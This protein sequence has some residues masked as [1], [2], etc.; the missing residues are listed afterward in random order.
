MVWCIFIFPS[1]FTFFWLKSAFFLNLQK[2]IRWPCQVLLSPEKSC[3]EVVILP[4]I[5]LMVQ[6][7][8]TS[9]YHEYLINYRLDLPP[10]QDAIKNHQDATCWG[11]RGVDPNYR[12]LYIP[13]GVF[14]AKHISTFSAKGWCG[15]SPA[16]RTRRRASGALW[17]G[18]VKGPLYLQ[19]AY[20]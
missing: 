19:L 1:W 7:S 14:V 3:W 9:W 11:F 5:L 16:C 15:R 12:V 17:S 6:K 4:K 10:I 20:S 2:L 18:G 8:C 13:H